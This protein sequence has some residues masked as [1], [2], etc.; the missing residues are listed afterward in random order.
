MLVKKAGSVL[1]SVGGK[2]SS[3]HKGSL[4]GTCVVSLECD[5]PDSTSL[6]REVFFACAKAG[7]AILEMTSQKASLEDIYIELT[8]HGASA[9]ANASAGEEELSQQ[10]ADLVSNKDEGGNK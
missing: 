2:C 3:V 1:A 8:E 4:P 9:A 5:T 10:P 6:C 7:V